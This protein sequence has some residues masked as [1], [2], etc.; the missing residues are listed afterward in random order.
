MAKGFGTPG[1]SGWTVS[2]SKASGSSKAAYLGGNLGVGMGTTG[3]TPVS[4]NVSKAGDAG[5]GR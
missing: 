1:K 2:N 5:Q 3:K 4:T